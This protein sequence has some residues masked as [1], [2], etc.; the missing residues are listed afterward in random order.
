MF[1]YVRDAVR[2]EIEMKLDEHQDGLATFWR[3]R[4]LAAVREAGAA[5]DEPLPAGTCI[6]TDEWDFLVDCLEELVLWDTDYAMGETFLDTDPDVSRE[7]MARMTIDPDYF[8]FPA[9]DPW[10]K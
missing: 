9:P 5:G 6:D 3:T 1:A 10:R 8:T 7:L 4:V 2:E